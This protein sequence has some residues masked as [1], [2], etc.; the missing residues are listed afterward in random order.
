[1]RLVLDCRPVNDCCKD[2]PYSNLATPSGLSGLN[3]S[4]EWVEL[5]SAFDPVG[6]DTAVDFDFHAGGVDLQDGFY[7]F[8]VPT[9]SSW[10]GLGEQLSAGSI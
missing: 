8:L 5:C 4:D 3:L 7:Q 1:M 9:V 10:F 6:D 2:A